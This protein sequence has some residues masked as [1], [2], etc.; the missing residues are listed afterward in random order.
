MRMASAV[1]VL[2][3]KIPPLNFSVRQDWVIGCVQRTGHS[4]HGS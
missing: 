1:S 3:V 4:S 2:K